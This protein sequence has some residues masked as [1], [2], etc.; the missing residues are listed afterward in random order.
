MGGRRVTFLDRNAHR[1]VALAWKD[2]LRALGDLQILRCELKDL[3][4][5]WDYF[6]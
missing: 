6:G 1:D 3:K 2:S 4:Q 5:S